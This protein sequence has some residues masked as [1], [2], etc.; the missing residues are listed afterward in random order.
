MR[1]APP[2]QPLLV[3]SDIGMFLPF[4]AVDRPI[5]I[6]NA[7]KRA[8]AISN[9]RT[10]DGVRLPQGFPKTIPPQSAVALIVCV[11]G[12]DAPVEKTITLETDDAARP[13]VD[14]VIRGEPDLGVP[15]AVD[16]ITLGKLTA[17]QVCPRVWQIENAC[18]LGTACHVV[19]SSPHVVPVI[20]EM[21]ETG[22]FAVDIQI[23]AN[24][25][26][27]KM[28]WYLFA[29]TGVPA[30]PF[31]AAECKAEII[32]GARLSPENA[33]FGMVPG[34]TVAA[35]TIDI[36]VLD[37]QW[38]T[39]A[40]DPPQEKC[41]SVKVV[42]TEPR[43]YHLEVSLDPREMPEA[44][45]ATVTVHNGRGDGLQIPVLAVRDKG[46]GMDSGG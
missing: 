8:V 22:S 29:T 33:F 42:K 37:S 45:H 38:E 20:R 34:E 25:P 12:A 6:Q 4:G 31:L 32:R 1:K 23:S 19:A 30:R 2:V 27:G 36:E 17:G 40:V 13:F 14:C 11:R 5:L 7:G 16:G 9:V 44:L 18:G 15:Y 43:K 24:A 10:C 35:R 3:K 28:A 46:N 41:L 26:R 39:V 21:K